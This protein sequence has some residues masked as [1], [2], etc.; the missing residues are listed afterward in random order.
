MVHEKTIYEYNTSKPL[1]KNITYDKQQKYT[2]I[3]QKLV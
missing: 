3:S 1:H 2:E